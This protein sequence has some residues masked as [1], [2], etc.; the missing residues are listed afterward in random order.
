MGYIQDF[1]RELEAMFTRGDDKDTIVRFVKKVVVE[2]YK[3][4]I[5]A[6]KLVDADHDA[7][8]KA[9]RFAGRK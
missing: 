6:A 4:G 8:R 7:S 1:D 3:N 5:M 9:A 2:S